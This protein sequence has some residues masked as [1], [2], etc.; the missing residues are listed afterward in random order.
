VSAAVHVVRTGTANLASVL[1]ALERAGAR[2]VLTADARE[3]AA[4]PILVLP[5]VGAFGAAMENLRDL[6]PALK[7]RVGAR[8][9]TLGICLGLQLLGEASDE[10]PGV[11]GLSVVPKRAERLRGDVRVPQI[12]WNR[13]TADPECELLEEGFAYYA[14]SYAWPAPAPEGWAGATTEHGVR[15]L[16]AVE[17]GPVLACQFHPELSG[18]WGAALLARWLLRAKEASC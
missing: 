12:G 10:S 4:A 17:R 16:A 14:N 15:F 7:D 13:V 18:A 2:P 6:A 11:A 5:G 3:V 8:R 9:P 1:A